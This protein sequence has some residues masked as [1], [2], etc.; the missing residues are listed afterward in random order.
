M[1]EPI[2]RQTAV[3]RRYGELV[4]QYLDLREQHPGVILLFRVGSF[5]EI[6][7]EDA[8]LATGVLGLKLSER[9]SGGTAAPVP[10]CGF[11]AQA[12]DSYLPRLLAHGYRVAVCEEETTA[13]AG[14]R[15]RSVVRTLTPGTVTDPRL[16][17]EDQPSYLVAVVM[18]ADNSVQTGLAWT[19]LAAGE[20]RAG[21]FDRADA[22]AEIARLDP[23]EILLP[24]GGAVPEQL[25]RNRLV[26]AVG[27]ADGAAERVRN[28]YPDAA[29]SDLPQAAAAAGIILDYLERT[30][31]AG[32]RPVLEAPR[33]SAAGD[34]VR[35]DAATLRH[36]EIV[37]T[38]H[39]HR[40][41]GSL[42][43]ILDRTATPMGQRM[44]RDWL[45]RPLTDRR[46][47]AARHRMVAEL[48]AD[49]LRREALFAY[50]Q[51][52]SDLERLAGRTASRHA[53]PDDLRALSAVAALLP[54]LGEV[55]ASC[56]SSFLRGLGRPQ[57]LLAAFAHAADAILAPD[58]GGQPVLAAAS[59]ELARARR[60][61]DEAAAWQ[62][63]FLAEL[64][65]ATGITRL[66]LDRSST[67]GLYL[68]TPA[69][70]AVP[71]T[72]IRRGGLQ[73]VERY[74]TLE[75]EEH[76]ARLAEAEDTANSIA[77]A[78]L[79]SLRDEAV[80]VTGEARDLARRLAAADALLSLA[81]VAAERGWTMPQVDDSGELAIVGGRHPVAEQAEDG[82]QA[83]DTFLSASAPHNQLI[84]LTGPNMAGKSTWMRQTALIALLAQAGSFVPSESARVGP[85]SW[86][87][88][89]RRPP[90]CDGRPAKAW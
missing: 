50:L 47:I 23:A 33:H 36:L 24:A 59:P 83:N 41:Q 10:Q 11:T 81:I 60:A 70:T 72:W 67:Q 6:L 39:A 28:A 19:D 48:V 12:L 78:L 20:F 55:T 29:M 22:E 76:A 90:C 40:R 52:L 63:R 35:L 7:F 61:V 65:R 9:S 26:T 32:D 2:G 88:C 87:K 8:E 86:L 17:R 45:L 13:G 30:Q 64:R 89:W 43:A 42:L 16:L 5:Y 57:P 66:R 77:A 44:L 1:G 84:V 25:T 4:R 69:N 58:A 73:R 75:L 74:T 14:V 85:P 37:E 53:S 51:P 80:A 18:Q 71:P 62:T 27:P 68:E 34:A 79:D 46:K 49:P 31:A 15:N 82:F 54:R 56:A 3:D 21:E 38:E